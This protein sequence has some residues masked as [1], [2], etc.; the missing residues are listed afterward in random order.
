MKKD[1][2]ANSTEEETQK[3][4]KKNLERSIE[5][6]KKI[7]LYILIILLTVIVICFYFL[8]SKYMENK[9]PDSEN[10]I[11]YMEK[12]GK[13]F[14]E[15]YYYPQL[16]E[17]KKNDMIE[18]IPIFLKNFTDTGISV[19]LK[20]VIDLHFRTEE[21]I[22]KTLEKYKCDFSKTQFIIYPQE[23]YEKKSYKIEP[24]IVCE[25]I[26]LEK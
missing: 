25:K 18:D 22:N 16:G 9:K 5:R 3:N 19:S 10:V 21:S 13:E 1:K 7:I 20:K 15:S 4:E 8:T 23:P 11:E 14:Y 26:N 12:L 17:L 2:N 6:K 24:Q